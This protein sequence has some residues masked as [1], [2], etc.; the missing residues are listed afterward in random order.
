MT[1][2]ENPDSKVHGANM[3]PTWVLSA[4]DGPHVGRM[5]LAIREALPRLVTLN[6]KWEPLAFHRI[7]EIGGRV[8]WDERYNESPWL[9]TAYVDQEFLTFMRGVD[10][11]L[12]ME[13][14]QP[15]DTPERVAVQLQR[16]P[17]PPY[18]NDGFVSVLQNIMPLLI[19]LGFQ[20]TVPDLTSSITVEKEKRLKVSHSQMVTRVLCAI[21]PIAHNH[22]CGA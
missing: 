22:S 13:V 17:Y 15:G 6:V 10:K 5:N 1:V 11:A 12:A 3:G 8:W 7:C 4:P 2:L 16:F 18:V 21:W 14:A 9:F 19:V 20:F